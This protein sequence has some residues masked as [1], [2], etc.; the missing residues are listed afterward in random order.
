MTFDIPKIRTDFIYPPIPIRSCDWQ[1]VYADDEPNENGSMAAGQG[2]TETEAI[3][4]LIENHPREDW[5]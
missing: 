5:S 2:A 3:L 4:D 1:A